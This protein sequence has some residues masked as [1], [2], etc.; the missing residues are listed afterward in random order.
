[1][2]DA[3]EVR[4]V[5]VRTGRI[6]CD[7]CVPDKRF[8]Q[9]TPKLAA[10]VAS[11]F[12]NIVRHACVNDAGPTFGAVMERTSLPH[13]LEHVAIDLQIQATQDDDALF[14]GTTEWVDARAGLARI[15]LSYTDDLEGLRAFRDAVNYLNGAVLALHHG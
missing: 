6:V 12:P 10:T 3:I 15:E 2:P 7:V 8:R 9:V 14:V 1:M 11:S 5:T 13:L 4:Q